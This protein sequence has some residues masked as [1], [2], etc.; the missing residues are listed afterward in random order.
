MGFMLVGASYIIISYVHFAEV[1]PT[2]FFVLCRATH[3][4]NLGIFLWHFEAIVMLMTMVNFSS[5]IVLCAMVIH[6]FDNL[7]GIM[8]YEWTPTHAIMGT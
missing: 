4:I 1:I 2:R 7:L 6:N 3:F 5:V 8:N